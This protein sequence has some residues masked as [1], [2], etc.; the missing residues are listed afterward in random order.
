MVS[1]RREDRVPPGWALRNP[2]ISATHTSR[3]T[4]NTGT[5]PAPTSA[6]L[7]RPSAPV[8]ASDANVAGAADVVPGAGAEGSEG[9][10]DS[11]YGTPDERDIKMVFEDVSSSS[12]EFDLLRHR[13][14]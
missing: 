9:D 5:G 4:H 12:G 11:E 2:A 1:Q 10:E 6:V 14:K 8:K 7:H 3:T 13:E